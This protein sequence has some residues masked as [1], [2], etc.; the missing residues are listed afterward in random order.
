MLHDL[1]HEVRL[2]KKRASH[3]VI[4]GWVYL[5][6]GQFLQSEGS[7]ASIATGARGNARGKS[8]ADTCTLI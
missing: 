5:L 1:F 8:R 6:G 4:H 3:D 2:F 7:I